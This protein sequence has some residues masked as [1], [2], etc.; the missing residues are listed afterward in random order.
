M[1]A[2]VASVSTDVGGVRDVITGPDVGRVVPFDDPAA[3]ANAVES[4]A[5]DPVG[6]AAMGEQARASVRR[7][8][9]ATRLIEDIKGLY[10]ELLGSTIAHERT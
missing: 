6:R 9:H 7:R 10:G 5:T 1:A 2:A 8:F 4:L 3:L